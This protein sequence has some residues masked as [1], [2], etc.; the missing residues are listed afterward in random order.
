LEKSEIDPVYEHINR[1]LSQDGISIHIPFPADEP[2]L[3][4]LTHRNLPSKK[5]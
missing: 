1:F 5:I 2:D 3:A 4:E